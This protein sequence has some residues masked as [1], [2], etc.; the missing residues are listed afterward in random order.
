[1]K[2]LA[3]LAMATL[4]A[5]AP[6]F[7]RAPTPLEVQIE[8]VGNSGIKAVVTN[9]GQKTLRLLKDGSFLDP[10]AVEHAHVFQGGM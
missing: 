2:F 8:R 4:A 9:N 7:K 5:A 6:G 1:M 3:G 10:A